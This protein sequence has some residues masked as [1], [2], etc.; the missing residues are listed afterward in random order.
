MDVDIYDSVAQSFDSFLSTINGTGGL[1]TCSQQVKREKAGGTT[2]RCCTY[3]LKLHH[4]AHFKGE[5]RNESVGVR[6]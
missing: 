3:T 6:A 1:H 5:R 4:L 2:G